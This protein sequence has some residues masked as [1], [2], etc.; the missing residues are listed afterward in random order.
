MGTY[1]A[2]LRGINVG[3]H[4]I[5]KMADLRDIITAAG[6]RD[7]A[8]YIQ[9]GNAV[10]GHAGRATAK[11]AADLERAIERGAGFAVPVVVRSAAELAAVIADNPFAREDSDKLHVQFLAAKPAANALAK[12]V[13]TL[14]APERYMLQGRE[15]YLHLP[16]G[17][18]KSKLAV[19]LSRLSAISAIATARNWR[20][21]LELDRMVKQIST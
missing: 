12:L 8:T 7:V 13:P 14:F 21:V 3:G 11:V 2:L 1:V 9:S 16:D 4:R 19:A 6:G 5:L 18:G 15:I 17:M 20:T 10:F